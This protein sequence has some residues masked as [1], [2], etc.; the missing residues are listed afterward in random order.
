MSVTML[1]AVGIWQS[2]IEAIRSVAWLS[3]DV[4]EPCLSNFPREDPN[5]KIQGSSKH[6]GSNEA[7]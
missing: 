7:S 1:E 4:H 5:T 3:F 6:P 2:E